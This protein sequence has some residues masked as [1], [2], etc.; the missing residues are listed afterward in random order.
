MSVP[1]LR[2][3]GV[4]GCPVVERGESMF[5]VQRLIDTNADMAVIVG[6]H[7]IAQRHSVLPH[8]AE[9]GT[10]TPMLMARSGHTSMRSLVRYA[11]MF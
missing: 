5:R 1:T 9:D 7:G 11:R 2:P 10:P 6:V 3:V 8:D 4:R